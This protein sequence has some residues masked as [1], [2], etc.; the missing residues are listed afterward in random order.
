MDEI[1]TKEEEVQ[2][3]KDIAI[4][5]SHELLHGIVPLKFKSYLEGMLYDNFSYDES[6]FRLAFLGQVKQELYNRYNEL[7]EFA[8]QSKT[9]ASNAKGAI[10]EIKKKDFYLNQVIRSV[11]SDSG[12]EVTEG[13]DLDD[14]QEIKDLQHKII[15]ILTQHEI[16]EVSRFKGLDDELSKRF[17][18]LSSQPQV[19]KKN[20]V[21]LMTAP[22][23]MFLVAT[24]TGMIE[25]TVSKDVIAIILEEIK[26]IK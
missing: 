1:N 8:N 5:Y 2:F 21:D 17:K 14:L 3:A 11:Q 23:M 6:A 19:G 16:N 4:Q 10:E 7:I 24:L 9:H 22:V 15:D 12:I 13:V 26:K 25:E 18:T 20:I